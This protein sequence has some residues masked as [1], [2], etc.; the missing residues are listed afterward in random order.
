M[1]RKVKNPL[2]SRTSRAALE[3]RDKPHRVEVIP[4]K[5]RLGWRPTS[6]AW[7][8]YFYLGEG[9]YETI[10][11]SAKADDRVEADGTNVLD[12]SQAVEKVRGLYD[13]RQKGSSELTIAQAMD[14]YEADLE[15]RGG[16]VHNSRR[17]R[18]HLGALGQRV[19]GELEAKELRQWRDGL[20]KTLAPA[21]ANRTAT[22]LAAALNR[23][24]DLDTAIAPKRNA[25]RTGLKGIPDAEQSHNVIL[26][27]PVIRTLVDKASIQGK[28]FQLLVEVLASTGARISQVANLMVKDLQDRGAAPRLMVPV[29]R[30]GRGKK[31]ITHTSVPITAALA[32]EL[33][34]VAAGRTQTS[35]LLRKP[36]GAPWKK[37]DH[38]RPFAR[39]V[40][41][42]GLDPAEV[43]IYALRHSNIVRQI[44]AGIPIRLVAVNHD[45]SVA[46]I[47]RTYS[48]NIGDHS[49][50]LT[51]AALLDL[52][53]PMA[54][55]QAV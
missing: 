15:T 44:L 55:P 27:E 30:K 19:V 22:G 10:R 7:I 39:L 33:R 16:D 21:T 41:S 14:Q 26:P 49:D 1:P 12:Y 17:V 48:A 38:S 24:A 46:M 45:T 50:E 23:V 6:G 36:S 4:G 9:R 35:P 2:S 40:K 25:W 18:R 53:S 54:T 28:E 11:L 42:V 13:E 31:Q 20:T 29:S 3:R 43:T 32:A 8:G 52:R 5:V 47:E 34:K 37:S 51:R